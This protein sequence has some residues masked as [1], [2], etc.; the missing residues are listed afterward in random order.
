MKTNSFFQKAFVVFSLLLLLNAFLSEVNAQVER[1]E[2]PFW[3]SGMK[4]SEIE[5]LFYGKDIADYKV[6]TEE[7]VVITRVVKT[8]SKT[9]ATLKSVCGLLCIWHG[10]KRTKM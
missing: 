2:P 6:S 4:N 1:V 9:I 7:D 3:W 10:V 5:I 8:K